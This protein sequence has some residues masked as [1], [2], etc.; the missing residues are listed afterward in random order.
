LSK[1]DVTAA[2]TAA[3]EA[4]DAGLD[5]RIAAELLERAKAEGVSLVGQGGLLQQVTRAVLQAALE[6]EMVVHLGYERSQT[7]PPGSGNHRDGSSAKTVR[8]ESVRHGWMCRAT[9][10]GRSSR[11]SCPSTPAGSPGSTR[12]SSPC[13]PRV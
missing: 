13:T 10:T 11:R 9:G 5:V 7:P 2:G 1:K 6:G 3:G 12:R 8:T 4:P